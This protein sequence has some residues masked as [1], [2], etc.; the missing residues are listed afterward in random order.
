MPQTIYCALITGSVILVLVLGLIAILTNARTSSHEALD[1]TATEPTSTIVHPQYFHM[2]SDGRLHQA[3]IAAFRLQLS[4]PAVGNIM[5]GMLIRFLR[6]DEASNIFTV[7]SHAHS[8]VNNLNNHWPEW[9]LV[10]SQPEFGSGDFI[11]E[12]FRSDNGYDHMYTHRHL[13]YNTFQ[14]VLLP[15]FERSL[16]R[17][18]YAAPVI[19]IRCSDGPF[20][21]HPGY[22]L[23]GKS[24]IESVSSSL[25]A[26]GHVKAYLVSCPY[27]HGVNIHEAR[28]FVDWYKVS[29]EDMGIEVTLQCG[30]AIEDF[31]YL[32]H[33]PELHGNA[34]SFLWLAGCGRSASTHIYGKG[35]LHPEWILHHDAVQD[36]TDV[37]AVISMLS[38]I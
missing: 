20:N 35:F 24:R 8:T 9:H 38:K 10:V 3:N 4:K 28:M 33:A 30:T 19:Y 2:I 13:L 22:H 12:L 14:A 18:S 31:T 25:Q 16:P 37:T 32:V 17:P 26:N 7:T 11:W 15:T 29:F 36:Y 21:R 5:S 6:G 1:C 23:L 34:S 27:H